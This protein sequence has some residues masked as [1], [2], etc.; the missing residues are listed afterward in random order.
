MSVEFAIIPV[1]K[2]FQIIADQIKDKLNKL[3]NINV[4]SD[5]DTDYSVSINK[6]VNKWKTKQ[7]DIIIIDHDYNETNSII[8]NFYDKIVKTQVM[9]IDEFIELVSSFED[10]DNKEYEL[11]N[12]EP[13]RN[14]INNDDD[15]GFCVI[16]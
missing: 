1:I 7:Y 9:Q 14:G 10:D 5:I 8:V 6:R 11:R 12:I 3:S 4:T 2:S 16:S 15:D 13:T